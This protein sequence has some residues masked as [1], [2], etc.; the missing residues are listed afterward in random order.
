MQWLDERL[1][2]GRYPN[3]A[4]AIEQFE[5]SRR[6]FLRDIDYMRLMLDAPIAYDRRRRGYYYTDPTFRLSAVQLREGELFSLLVADKVL[7][8]YQGTPYENHLKAAFEKICRALPDGI[9][10]D[11]TAADAWLSFDMGPTRAPD[12][13]T[14]QTFAQAVRDC[15]AVRMRYHTQSRNRDTDRIVEPYHLHNHKGDWYLIAFCRMRGTVRDFL[16][17]RVLRAEPLDEGFLVPD[18]F[19]FAAYAAQSFD[20]EKGGDPVQ[21]AV[22]FDAYQARWIRERQWH[23]TQQ[24]VEHEDGS[25]TMEFQAAGLDE[26]ARWVLS[27]GE[28]AVVLEPLRLREHVI[29]AL[30][31]AAANYE[32]TRKNEKFFS[33]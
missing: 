26:V 13:E 1:R 2:N 19:D 29:Q 27:Y 17:S 16:L 22:R 31:V 21:V 24:I 18:D 6:T 12:I 10:V 28:H 15:V 3:V 4:E 30:T 11:L 5:V 8:Q 25:L 33:G 20:V 32:A 23:P 7:R 14:F 9:T